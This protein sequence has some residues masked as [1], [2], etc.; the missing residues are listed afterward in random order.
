MSP[1]TKIKK[2]RPSYG[3]VRTVNTIRRDLFIPKEVREN[4][5]KA[6]P[7]M[8]FIT[9]SELSQ[10]FGI[11]VSSAKE[12]LKDLEKKK[13]IKKNEDISNPKLWVFVPV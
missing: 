3:K 4:I 6:I 10:K 11:R 9:P 12:L 8:K 5:E 13:V 7:K 2:L 1:E